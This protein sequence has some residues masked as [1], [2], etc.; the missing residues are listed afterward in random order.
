MNTRPTAATFTARPALRVMAATVL[1]ALAAATAQT[2]Q[3]QPGG[4]PHGPRHGMRHGGA[5]LAMDSPRMVE[6]MLDAVSASAEQRAQI[7]QLA[8]TARAEMRAQHESG[9]QL[10]EQSAALFAQ[11]T[12]DAR[13]AEALR[14]QMLAR[15]DQ[16]SK[17][18]LQLML[19]ISRVLTPEQRKLLADRM[20]QRR[21]MME[22]H[23]G[24]KGARP[25][26]ATKPQT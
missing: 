14:Q 5:D 7:K 17:R 22:K 8:D 13:A 2:A 10:R 4:E 18:Q 25:T 3:A 9:R 1:L 6:R 16:A 24:E 26:A 12:V 11:P 20:V 19:D 15:H 21:A 23:R